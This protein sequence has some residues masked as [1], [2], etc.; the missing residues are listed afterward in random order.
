MMVGKKALDIAVTEIL[1]NVKKLNRTSKAY[2]RIL[3]TSENKSY[4]NM[5][6]LKNNMSG[7]RIVL[8]NIEVERKQKMK[9]QMER[10]CMGCVFL[11]TVSIIMIELIIIPS[12][13]GFFICS[14]FILFPILYG[15]FNSSVIL[16]AVLDYQNKSLLLYPFTFFERNNLKKQIILSL[17]D[18]KQIK[19][20]NKYLKIYLKRGDTKKD[21]K[22]NSFF[23]TSM[24]PL[25]MP[26]YTLSSASA[27]S[28]DS[29]DSGGNVQSNDTSGNNKDRL[30]SY[31][32]NN[33]NLSV[34]NKNKTTQNK[35]LHYIKKSSE[36]YPL[37]LIEENKLIALLK[38]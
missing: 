13:Y 29:T 34:F 35:S 36:G 4:S 8:F 7:S 30:Y 15:L 18:I 21:G 19:K 3:Y 26:R 25:H 27:S 37:N 9:K 32:Y 33:F 1:K 16:R 28:S 38:L 14:G 24:M 10:I 20:T 31:D 6:H 11:S 22:S 17:Y 12:I 2:I 23:F 5:L